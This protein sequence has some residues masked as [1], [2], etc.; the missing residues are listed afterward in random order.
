MSKNGKIHPKDENMSGSEPANLQRA[1]D[2]TSQTGVVVFLLMYSVAGKR[3]TSGYPSSSSKRYKGSYGKKSYRK[4]TSGVR[5]STYGGG[6]VRMPYSRAF[7]SNPSPEVVQH[8][9]L[10]GASDYQH[11]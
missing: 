11:L 2:H 5:Q 6:I 7:N 8:L 1:F 10:L 4:K 9:A 3:R